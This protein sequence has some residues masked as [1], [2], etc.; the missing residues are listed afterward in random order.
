MRL[1]S[2]TQEEISLLEK[3]Y[4]PDKDTD[5]WEP[6]NNIVKKAIKADNARGI[7]PY[8]SPW[9]NQ[10]STVL[11]SLSRPGWSGGLNVPSS[12]VNDTSFTSS[13]KISRYFWWLL[14]LFDL[15]QYKKNDW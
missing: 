14:E 2:L 15:I 7:A 8:D 10:D 4:T 5:G 12:H 1:A 11:S 9:P 13:S 3:G 6:R